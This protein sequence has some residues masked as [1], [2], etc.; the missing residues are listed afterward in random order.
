MPDKNHF[1]LKLPVAQNGDDN[2]N[3][4]TSN[5]NETTIEDS[6]NDD[7]AND[8]DYILQATISINKS[9]H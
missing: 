8:P 5:Y 2:E 9:S 6:T 3:L 7:P 1:R 4:E